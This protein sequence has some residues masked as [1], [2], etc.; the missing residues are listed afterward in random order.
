MNWISDRTGQVWPGYF[1]FDDDLLKAACEE[2]AFN[3]RV[4]PHSYM[5][6]VGVYFC[7]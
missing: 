2:P 3:L 4:S 1:R 7:K 6:K 5:T